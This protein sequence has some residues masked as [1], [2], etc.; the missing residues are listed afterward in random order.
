MGNQILRVSHLWDEIPILF[1]VVER[2]CLLRHPGDDLKGETDGSGGGGGE[3]DMLVQ[4]PLGPV[5]RSK[6]RVWPTPQASGPL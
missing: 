3:E 4:V 5:A 6:C 1:R 2:K